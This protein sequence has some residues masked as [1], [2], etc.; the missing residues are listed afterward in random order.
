L[1]DA[2]AGYSYRSKTELAAF[3]NGEAPTAGDSFV[4]G[5]S[6]SGVGAGNAYQT[7][8]IVIT[9]CETTFR[10]MITGFASAAILG[11]PTRFY[12]GA[13]T[14]WHAMSSQYDS[15]GNLLLPADSP[16]RTDTATRSVY[17]QKSVA[18]DPP[19]DSTSSGYVNDAY[20]TTANQIIIDDFA[21]KG[22]A[23]D[24]GGTTGGGSSG[25]TS[26]V[27]NGCG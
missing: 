22:V 26:P 16:W 14:E 11:L 20:G 8:D 9:Y 15:N 17:L 7:G 24:T 10:A 12:D 6:P 27:P 25:G 4:S 5:D 2:T 13:M 21:Y 23:T 19:A 3:L 1:L 18:V